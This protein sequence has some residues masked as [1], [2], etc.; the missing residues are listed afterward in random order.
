MLDRQI[1][2]DE[3]QLTDLLTH[4]KEAERM[5]SLVSD[6]VGDPEFP[7]S[8]SVILVNSALEHIS[9]LT[10]TLTGLVPTTERK[11]A[12][13]R[14]PTIIADG[15]TTIVS[16]MAVQCGCVGTCACDLSVRDLAS[17]GEDL[18]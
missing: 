10:K 5:L 3:G 15:E 6:H 14:V 9:A 16:H 11:T 17:L 2:V 7:T 8:A 1:A 4:G 13:W 12:P 18:G